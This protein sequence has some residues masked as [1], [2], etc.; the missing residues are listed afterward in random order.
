M[1]RVDVL[2]FVEHRDRE[3]DTA[4]KVGS[5]L[6]KRFGRS[7]RI[8]PIS[9][10]TYQSAVRVQPSAVVVP[11]CP[12]EDT[13]PINVF[14]ELYGET[15]DYVHLGFEQL[16]VDLFT[17]SH[18]PRDRFSR[19]VPYHLG[20]NESYAQWLTSSGVPTDRIIQMGSPQHAFYL[21]DY[22]SLLPPREEIAADH[23]LDPNKRWALFPFNYGGAFYG[24]DIERSMQRKGLP[25]ELLG[26]YVDFCERSFEEA[27]S[28]IIRSA[29]T[30]EDILFMVRPR[31]LEDPMV[32][33][34]RMG[35][36]GAVPPNVVVIKER[37]VRDWV[38]NSDVVF[39]SFS[40]TLLDAVLAGKPAYSLMPYDL[41]GWLVS[42][43]TDLIPMARSFRNFESALR[44]SDLDVFRAARE[45][46][47]ERFGI[48][49][50]D[51]LR[52]VAVA[53]DN[54]LREQPAELMR[55][56]FPHRSG[57]LFVQ[58]LREA[59]IERLVKF[60][61]R[62][63]WLPNSRSTYDYFDRRD[64]AARVAGDTASDSMMP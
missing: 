27:M 1:Q 28:W 44:E 47:N 25:P 22:R 52:R 41:P 58:A 59:G 35:G 14:W 23:G 57:R 6:Q 21:P 43:W 49:G 31:P 3:L 40:T 33:I 19:E 18:V 2:Y 9:F 48:D 7:V 34:E 60:G 51:P 61:V 11:F 42:D 36:Q 26:A 64:A 20:W 37:P 17:Y 38:V 62:A 30:S 29:S 55:R 53:V 50:G 56:R 54:V 24:P 16:L 39:S 63:D 10:G 4:V 46:A 13:F 45:Y 15:I 5:I 8:E 12:S 32:Y